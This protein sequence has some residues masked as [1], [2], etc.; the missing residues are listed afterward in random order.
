MATNLKEQH[1]NLIIAIDGEA[2]SGKGTI[3]KALADNFNLPYLD[4]G[5][6]YRAVGFQ[7]LENKGNPNNECD[8][9]LSCNFHESVLDFGELRA[10]EIGELASK[11]SA[12]PR[13]RSE[14]FNRQRKFALQEGGAVLD[15]RD[16][17]TTIAPEAD[18]KIFVV[19]DL[20]ERARRR[21]KDLKKVND[22]IRYEDVYNGLR[23]RDE[24]DKNREISPMLRAHD[25]YCIDSTNMSVEMNVAVALCIARHQKG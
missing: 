3:A 24:R 10:D 1:K 13:V 21:F 25:A 12:F 19:C 23:I 18:L 22:T 14:L 4:T 20:E 6:L 15:G 8:A 16:I 17:G 5:L 7:L 11:V 9:L 2:A